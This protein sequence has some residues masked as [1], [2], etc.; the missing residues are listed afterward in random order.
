MAEDSPTLGVFL[1]GGAAGPDGFMVQRGLYWVY[2]LSQ[3]S[4]RHVGHMEIEIIL[5][6]Y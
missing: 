3:L 1:G 4:I 5:S 2:T 6:N